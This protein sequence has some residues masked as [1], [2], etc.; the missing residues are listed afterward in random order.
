MKV[1]APKAIDIEY[2]KSF[3][4]CAINLK[5]KD[6]EVFKQVLLLAKN[7][8]DISSYIKSE[9]TKTS[10]YYESIKL[11]VKKIYDKCDL[12]YDA[13]INPFI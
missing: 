12:K 6:L 9:I 1:T 5:K 4:K 2:L 3:Y 13:M 11:K 10:S 8:S 7:S